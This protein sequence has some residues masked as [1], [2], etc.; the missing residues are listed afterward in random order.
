M[1]TLTRNEKHVKSESKC[2][3]WDCDVSI[4]NFGAR[5]CENKSVDLRDHQYRIE[6]VAHER[7]CGRKTYRISSVAT[8]RVFMPN[9]ALSSKPTVIFVDDER[10][11]SF[12]QL[13]S[14]LRKSGFRTVRV[15]VRPSGWRPEDLVFD[16]NISLPSLPSPQQLA[17]ILSSEYIT[18]IQPTESLAAVTY[19]ALDLV[20]DSQR[21]DVWAGRTAILDKWRI[22]S[23]LR[24]L[25]LRTPDTLLAS[26]TS[27][28]DAVSSLSLPIVLK[29]RVGSSG[30]NVKVFDSLE[31]VQEFVAAIETPRDWFFEQFISGQSMVC[32]SCVSNEGIDVIATYAVLK[33]VHV[34]GPASV[35]EIHNDAGLTDDGRTLFNALH[36]RGLMCFDVIRD[37]NGIDWVHDVNPRVFGGLSMCQLSGFNF[38]GSYVQFLTGQDRVASH[39]RSSPSTVSFAFP[40][41]RKDLFRSKPRATAWI[42]TLLWIS[43]NWRLLGSR[44]FLYFVIERPISSC[45]RLLGRRDAK[46]L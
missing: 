42:R 37:S 9:T 28:T 27:P 19:A 24:E 26:E 8:S 25:G 2:A 39:G 44:Y 35:V 1:A 41:G 4:M 18:D 5:R 6:G 13:S 40:E 32:A 43:S 11:E 15:S 22:A 33:R 31:S 21:S 7:D 10:W 16:R 12:L 3:V 34:R 14:I 17:E 46:H 36:T 29:R 20:P 38:C 23:F 45:R 30:S